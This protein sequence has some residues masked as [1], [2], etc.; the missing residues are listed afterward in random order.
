MALTA[1]KIDID[2]L[3]EQIAIDGSTV[4]GPVDIQKHNEKI[5]QKLIDQS[6]TGMN[7][8]PISPVPAGI[9]QTFIGPNTN[10]MTREQRESMNRRYEAE[11]NWE[12]FISEGQ[13]RDP[14]VFGGGEFG[15]G[16]ARTTAD[17]IQ[18]APY[19]IAPEI[20]G[21]KLL[22]WYR[23]LKYAKIGST[24]KVGESA[25]RAFG[26]GKKTFDTTKGLRFVDGFGVT[27]D[28][29]RIAVESKVGRTS[30]SEFV[31]KQIA[32]DAEL[33]ATGEVDQVIWRFAKSPKTGKVGPTAPLREALQKEGIKI[34]EVQ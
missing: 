24:G 25:L 15:F 7:Q 26:L 9:N 32:K 13:Q 33:L 1:R 11:R 17:A 14:F 6:S 30:L 5:V 18:E 27:D 29:I 31:Q 8:K 22:K 19:V 34:L 3:E 12:K 2:G 20:A 28:G 16:F 10:P 4:T 21:A 23:G